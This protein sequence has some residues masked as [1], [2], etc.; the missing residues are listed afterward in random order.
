MNNFNFEK[1]VPK[2]K[3]KE[4]E[5]KKEYSPIKEEPI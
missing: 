2:I 3:I 4:A 5:N 1:E